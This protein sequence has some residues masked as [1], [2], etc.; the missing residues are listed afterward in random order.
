MPT[1][2]VLEVRRRILTKAELLLNEEKDRIC[3]AIIGHERWH[4]KEEV[5]EEDCHYKE[6]FLRRTVSAWVVLKGEENLRKGE[7]KEHRSNSK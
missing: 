7:S 2:Q 3:G 5:R 6:T 1:N 4:K